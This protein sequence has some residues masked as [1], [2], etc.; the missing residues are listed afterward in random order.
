MLCE[1]GFQELVRA[2]HVA[3]AAAAADNEARAEE[4][5][6]GTVL[7]QHFQEWFAM[8]KA[9]Q[10]VISEIRRIQ[11]VHPNASLMDEAIL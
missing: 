6:E 9:S 10:Q 11:V 2:I 7:L 8:R 5:E 3:E 1:F 4:D